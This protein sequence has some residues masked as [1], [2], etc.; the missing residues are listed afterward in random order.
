MEQYRRKAA[1]NFFKNS[2]ASLTS[3]PEDDWR[4]TI[5]DA[6]N[7]QKFETLKTEIDFMLKNIYHP[8]AENYDQ[9]SPSSNK[10][11]SLSG[12]NTTQNWDL[13]FQRRLSCSPYAYDLKGAE[14]TPYFKSAK[15]DLLWYLVH[16]KICPALRNAPFYDHLIDRYI[17]S[18]LLITY[19]KQKKLYLD[20]DILSGPSFYLEKLRELSFIANYG[21]RKKIGEKQLGEWLYQKSVEIAWQI[22]ERDRMNSVVINIENHESDKEAGR[23]KKVNT[24]LLNAINSYQVYVPLWLHPFYKKV[25]NQLKKECV[26]NLD[27]LLVIADQ[28]I[29]DAFRPYFKT[30]HNWGRKSLSFM[31][32]KVADF[33]KGASVFFGGVRTVGAMPLWLV[34]KGSENAAKLALWAHGVHSSHGLLFAPTSVEA[35]SPFQRKETEN[36]YMKSLE[37]VED[38]IKLVLGCVGNYLLALDIKNDFR[39]VAGRG[40][41]EFGR[42]N[43]W[44]NTGYDTLGFS[45]TPMHRRPTVKR[46]LESF[47]DHFVSMNFSFGREIEDADIREIESYFEKAALAKV[48]DLAQYWNEEPPDEEPGKPSPYEKPEIVLSLLG[49]LSTADQK[50][51]ERLFHHLLDKG[52]LLNGDQVKRILQCVHDALEEDPSKNDGSL[53]FK[54]WVKAKNLSVSDFLKGVIAHQVLHNAPDAEDVSELESLAEAIPETV[55]VKMLRDELEGKTKNLPTSISLPASGKLPED[56]DDVKTE[57][58]NPDRNFN[59]NDYCEKALR[60]NEALYQADLSQYHRNRIFL[61]QTMKKHELYRLTHPDANEKSNESES[62]FRKKQR[63]AWEINSLENQHRQLETM[64]KFTESKVEIP[65]DTFA[66]DTANNNIHQERYASNLSFSSLSTTNRA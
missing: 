5:K 50:D 10:E 18:V 26:K 44:V 43:L 13:R 63:L 20:K 33:V 56:E 55:R 15:N 25:P 17:D 58:V 29:P 2:K 64:I 24:A 27:G 47:R 48:F 45:E 22:S 6:D 12:D 39:S 42:L 53:R 51:S 3:P 1:K 49:I 46:A 62:C 7:V 61:T 37:N 60:E 59:F 28:D 21:E 54:R 38:F 16:Q 19:M 35:A 65:L 11:N 9:A 14:N 34:N 8:A 52:K 30:V 57:N 31:E 4:A 66:G 40:T 41:Q 32:D 36:R 23:S